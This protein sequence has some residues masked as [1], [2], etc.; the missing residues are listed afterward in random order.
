MKSQKY[1][2]L[3]GSC[4]YA[5]GL[6]TAAWLSG[7]ASAAVVVQANIPD[8]YQHQF[9]SFLPGA[10]GPVNP[11][12][13]IAN[14][15][16]ET[17]LG[18]TTSGGWCYPVAIAD[19]LYPWQVKAAYTN[20][21]SKGVAVPADISTPGK[22]LPAM[23]GWI[24]DIANNGAFKAGGINT[25]LNY[26]GLGPSAPAGQAALVST[27]YYVR[28]SGAVLQQ[29]AA[30]GLEV[31][32]IAG[33]NVTAVQWYEAQ[34]DKGA[35]SVITIDQAGGGPF[36]W[37]NYHAVAGAGYTNA[38]TILVADPDS[39]NGN[40]VDFPS[41]GGGD[42]KGSEQSVHRRTG[43][44]INPH[45]RQPQRRCRQ[46]RQQRCLWHLVVQGRRVH[47]RHQRQRRC[48]GRQRAVCQNRDFQPVS[49]ASVSGSPI[50]R[51]KGCSDRPRRARANRAGSAG[52]RYTTG[53]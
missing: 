28:P 8:F 53:N 19:A 23:S 9:W 50:H 32:K 12:G 21:D 24:P 2:R 11:T 30:G 46:L 40:L 47:R 35:S 48:R 33:A 45:R 25:Y 18:K 16:T 22:W 3:V 6:I 27:P 14:W 17:K 37:T 38:N 39:N 20:L 51:A 41:P 7:S 5:T 34:V 15:E 10:A 44:R 4:I 26:T 13:P 1:H 36:W 49:A 29:T 52:R 42:H 31:V 43:S